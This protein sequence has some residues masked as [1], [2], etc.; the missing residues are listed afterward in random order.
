MKVYNIM[1]EV[2][3]EVYHDSIYRFVSGPYATREKAME[4]MP[5]KGSSM[6]TAYDY[7][8]VEKEIIE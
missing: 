8:I 6:G 7:Y 3:D 4:H 2:Y 1:C 5:S